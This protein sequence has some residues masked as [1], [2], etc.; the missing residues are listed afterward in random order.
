MMKHYQNHDG[1]IEQ[2][3]AKIEN[4]QTVS[5]DSCL[6][7]LS[8]AFCSMDLVGACLLPIM[9]FCD[10]IA[11]GSILGLPILPRFLFV[12]FGL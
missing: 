2:L 1:K 3:T 7:S 8:S 10:I 6:L 12:M 4:K 11:S 5:V 9:E